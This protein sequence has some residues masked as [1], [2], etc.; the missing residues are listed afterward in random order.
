MSR[1]KSNNTFSF[2]P[3]YITEDGSIVVSGAIHWANL[4]R[5][6][7][8]LSMASDC[9]VM[10]FGETCKLV[11]AT[12]YFT[13]SRNPIYQCDCPVGIKDTS[14]IKCG[15]CQ[16]YPKPILKMADLR[17]KFANLI[18]RTVLIDWY[19]FTHSLE[20][21]KSTIYD[22]L[23]IIKCGECGTEAGQQHFITCKRNKRINLNIVVSIPNE[24]SATLSQF[25]EQV[26]SLR[27]KYNI[28]FITDK[29]LRALEYVKD[30]T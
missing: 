14:I 30:A 23:A 15:N 29:N 7:D 16:K 4:V 24:D 13:Q 2:S 3:W 27:D 5:M 1:R 12:K 8:E 11:S 28:M 20:D 19:L 25:E 10:V 26:V 21:I 9:R 6:Q 22:P 17:R 18:D